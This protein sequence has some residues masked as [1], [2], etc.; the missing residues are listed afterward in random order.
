MYDQLDMVLK[1]QFA[2]A[3]MHQMQ[4]KRKVMVVQLLRTSIFEVIEVKQDCYCEFYWQLPSLLPTAF[5]RSHYRDNA[6]LYFD[7]H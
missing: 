2:M 4:E 7:F 5:K 1:A 3:I 6:K